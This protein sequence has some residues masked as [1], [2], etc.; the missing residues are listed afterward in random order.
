MSC[1]KYYEFHYYNINIQL[2][3]IY[4]YIYLCIN[5]NSKT[6]MYLLYTESVGHGI[7]GFLI[8]HLLAGAVQL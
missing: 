7:P 1:E 2:H 5:E 4:I 3:K 8:Q 6:D